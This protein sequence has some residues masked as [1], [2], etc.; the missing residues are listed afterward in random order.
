MIPRYPFIIVRKNKQATDMDNNE[1]SVK[2]VEEQAKKRQNSRKFKPLRTLIPFILRYPKQLITALIMLILASL[3][4]LCIPLAIRSILDDGFSNSNTQAFVNLFSIMVVLGITVA[5]RFYFVSW[6]GERVTADLKRNVYNHIIGLDLFFFEKVQTGEILSRLTAD[7]TVIR[8]TLCTSVSIALRNFLTFIGSAIL[9]IITSPKLSL[10]IALILPMIIIPLIIYGRSLRRLSRITQDCVA[11]TNIQ[12]SETISSIQTIQT[13]T[14]EPEDRKWFSH[15]IETAFS[16]V[17]KSILRRSTLTAFAF[18]LIFSGIVGILWIG[19]QSILKGDM[20]GGT[21][22]QFMAYT[23]LC[24]VSIAALSEVWGNIQLAAGAMERLVEIL[25]IKP[26]ITTPK[27]PITLQKPISGEIIFDN[28]TFHYLGRPE[29]TALDKLSFKITAGETIA[30][31]GASGAGKSTIFQILLRFYDQQSGKI[32]LDGMDLRHINLQELRQQFSVVPQNTVIFANSIFENI[33]FGRPEATS[34]EIYA[35][36]HAAAL[37]SFIQSLPDGYETKLGEQGMNLS[38]GQRQRIAIA[39]AILR[40]AP[41]LLLDEATSALDSEN[42]IFVQEIFKKQMIHQTTL[43]IAHKLSTIRQ[44][45][46]ILV[47]D[48]G[49]IVESGTHTELLT[50]EGIYKKLSQ[51]QFLEKKD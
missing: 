22:G 40:N 7:T 21:L 5:M 12:A 1:Y 43:I 38:G 23:M 50:Q 6:L 48:K 29:I 28:V 18:A 15:Q 14:H 4:T 13:F 34:S 11:N 49:Q 36:T 42:E 19:A 30:L 8:I 16:A 31:V 35:A 2:A 25:N 24:A 39:R 37:D 44:V 45:D 51:L 26:T 9:L 41:I 20:T 47:I 32:T 46:R 33:R 3:S 17:R 10:M 27:N